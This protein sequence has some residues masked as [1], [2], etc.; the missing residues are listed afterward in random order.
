MATAVRASSAIPVIFDSVKIDGRRLV[1][2][3]VLDQVPVE[4]ARAMGADIVIG[5]SLGFSQV[6]D[7]PVYSHQLLSNVMDLMTREDITRSLFMA[8]IAIEIPGI[9]KTSLIDI[10]QRDTLIEMGKTAMQGR[11]ANLRQLVDAVENNDASR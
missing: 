7:Q 9:Q 10:K 8:D 11:I 2:G 4:V 6:Y 5:V 1:D 3:G